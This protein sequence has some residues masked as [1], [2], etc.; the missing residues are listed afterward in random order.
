MRKTSNKRVLRISISLF[1]AVALLVAAINAF[2]ST[3]PYITD[4][5]INFGTGNKYL[6]AADVRVPGPGASLSFTRTYNS[7]SSDTSVMGYGWTAS[8]SEKLIITASEITLIQSGGRYVHFPLESTG[9]W[10]NETGSRRVI[11]EITGGYQLQETDGSV[12]QFDSNGRLLLY[13]DRNNNI[14]T[15]TYSGAELVSI[16]NNFGG[17]ISFGYTGGNLTSV[18]SHLGTFSYSYD[19]NNNLENVTRPDTASMTYIYD[20]PN[21]IHNL[22]GVIN[23]EGERILTVEYDTSDRVIRSAKQGGSNEVNITY[24]ANYL[25]KVTNSLGVETTYHLDVLHGIVRVGSFSGPGCSSCGSTSDM[26]YL[27]DDRFRVKEQTDARG[28]VTSYTYDENGNK[29]SKTEAA[30]TP[31]EK[32]TTYTYYPGNKLHTIT[33][34]SIANPGRQSVTTM[35]YDGGGNLLTRTETGFEETLAI[36]RT[37]SYSY[38]S[39]GRLTTINGPRTDVGDIITMTYYPNEAAQGNNRGQLHT[40]TNSLGH[41][42]TYADYNLHGQA[43][44]ITDANGLV[45][46]RTFNSRGEMISS[47]TAG[48]TTSYSYNLAGDLQSVSLP[49][50]RTVTYGYDNAGRIN[51]ITDNQGNSITYSFDS[52][53]RK[54]GEDVHDPQDNLARFIDFEYDDSGRISKVNY[55]GDAESTAGY[56]AVGNLVQTI[57]AT[58]LQTD[59]TYDLLNRLESITE[60]GSSTGYQYDANNNITQVTDARENATSFLYDDLNRRIS[61]TAPDTGT[62]LYG[63]D[64]AGNLLSITDALSRIV[65][66]SYDALNRPV[67]QTYGNKT[68]S[69]AYDQNSNGKG[70]LSAISDEHGSRS[71]LYNSLGQLTSET[72][73]IASTSYTTAYDYSNTTGELESIIYPSG[74]EVGY[75]YGSDGQ[76]ASVSIDGGIIINAVTHLPFGPLNS[77]TLGSTVLTKDYDQ[78]YNLTGITAGSLNYIYSRDAEGHVTAIE[79]MPSPQAANDES[80]ATY[81][82]DSNKLQSTTGT[83]AKTY[84]YDDVGN[85]LSDGTFTY[86]Y[87]ELNRITEVR[88]GTTV[89]ATYGYDSS[90]RRIMKTVGSTTF[91]YLYDA[92]SNLIA[93]AAADGTIQREYIY[94]D[95]ELVA[96]KEYQTNPGLYYFINDHLGTPQR[97]ITAQGN[98]AWE[99]AYLPFGQAQ[100]T[101]EQVVNNIRFPGQ[102]YDVETGLHYNWHR[103]Y[104]PTTGRYITADPIGLAGGMNLYAY[105]EN[106]PVNW[107]DPEGLMMAGDLANYRDLSPEERKERLRRAKEFAERQRAQSIARTE[108]MGRAAAANAAIRNCIIQCIFENYPLLIPGAMAEGVFIAGLTVYTGGQ[109]LVAI[110][111]IDAASNTYSTYQLLNAIEDCKQRCECRE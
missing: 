73:V 8:L 60:D 17:I 88:D 2:A 27:Y 94:I 61:R 108:A 67:S 84:T 97:L 75:S 53:G 74:K 21:D 1:W 18:T 4:H 104:D 38:N 77:A 28:K 24:P 96:L 111:F 102:Y 32:I 89:V 95:G 19:T 76:V 85:T 92:D 107:I 35:T 62:T 91:H 78:R 87:D 100:V 48:L 41:V 20:D 36:S 98:V 54:T 86:I 69:F 45:T 103:F 71:F 72:R 23:E 79:N 101:V 22:T 90:N 51:T 49:G 37:T 29:L 66:F 56:D 47:T 64:E 3:Q 83:R 30:G 25:R 11:T 13:T 42:T 58:G 7:Q 33:T 10:V 44:T 43:E 63:Y 46:T 31:L 40:V 39:S 93:E 70:R 16:S 9:V 34:E 12:K 110:A 82:A 68:I 105:V 80:T 59:M 99:A 15:Y 109:G 5:Q 6:S 81:P 55:P 52:E 14:R 106:D 65:G 57:N 26:S 50:S